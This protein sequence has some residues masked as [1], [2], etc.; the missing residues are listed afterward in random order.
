MMVPKPKHVLF[1]TK[2]IPHDETILKLQSLYTVNN[3]YFQNNI[4]M[5]VCCFWLNHAQKAQI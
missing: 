2:K 4:Q 5:I 1:Y 3:K